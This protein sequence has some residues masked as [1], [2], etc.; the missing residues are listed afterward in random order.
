MA[1]TITSSLDQ[2]GEVGSSKRD[3]LL[4]FNK[5]AADVEWM[6]SYLTGD[7]VGSGVILSRG[8]T[9]TN[10]ATTA[11]TYSVAGIPTLV[12]AVAAGTAFGALGTIPL[13]TW[14][15]ITLDVALNGTFSFQSG[16]AN[17]TTGYATEAAAIVALPARITAVAR[18]GYVTILTKLAT[19]FVVG[20]DA[21]AGGATGNPATTT[22]YYPNGILQA[23][24]TQ[25]NAVLIPTVLSR[26]STDTNLKNTAF[27]YNV[28]GATFAK[29]AVA[30][31]TAFGALGTIP[32]SKW[33]LIAVEINSAG[34]FS[35]VSANNYGTGNGYGSETLALAAIPA[36]P[37]ATKAR[38][39]YITVLASASTWIAGTD[40]LAGGATG[41]P[42]TTTNYYAGAGVTP[43]A[44]MLASQIGNM[45]G[46]PI[47]V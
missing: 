6:R 17:Y 23:T 36:L 4:N 38:V 13:N 41:N 7:L 32:A 44:G 35:F 28:S 30:A 39:G 19:N 47:T 21:L 46:V 10:L 12:A 27:T 31:G 33:G 5:L 20:T 8:S 11:F 15:I 22:N 25:A 43:Q 1:G 3:L 2:S 29:A 42:A 26:G 9:D 37:A 40:A 24:G 14:G 34:T 45:M 16:A 18:V